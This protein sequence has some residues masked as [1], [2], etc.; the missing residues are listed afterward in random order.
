MPLA[1][2][3]QQTGQPFDEARYRALLKKMKKKKPWKIPDLLEVEFKDLMGPALD[4]PDDLEEIDSR[5]AKQS[6]DALID[7]VDRGEEPV[8]IRSRS[9]SEAVLVSR[10]DY[11][12]VLETEALF[13]EMDAADLYPE[14]EEGADVLPFPGKKSAEETKTALPLDPAYKKVLQF[15][16]TVN[17]IRP[18]IWRR[19]QI[20]ENYTFWDLHVAIQDAMGWEN[21]HMHQ[22][23][24]AADNI[25]RESWVGIPSPEIDFVPGGGILPAWGCRVADYLSLENPKAEYLYDLGND[26]LHALVLEKIMDR[27]KGQ[28]YPRCIKGKRACPSEDC[29]GIPGYYELV[30]AMENPG[31]A[32]YEET[33]E[34]LGEEYDPDLFSADEIIF[35][36]PREQLTGVFF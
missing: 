35:Q 16:I 31:S 24:I 11:Q 12:V 23:V 8:L 10:S 14:N 20:P 13:A 27:Q 17:G 34:W 19:I 2:H 32:A 30:E 7:R 29:G 25:E 4:H 6:L 18:P 33:L 1:I 5:K 3:T 22:F 28:S 21:M 9:G 15:K 36:D 26:W